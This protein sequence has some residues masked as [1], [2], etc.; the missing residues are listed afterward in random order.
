MTWRTTPTVAW[1]ACGML[2]LMP[3][4]PILVTGAAGFIG[5]HVVDALVARGYEV[6]A[7]DALLPA[8]HA[9]RPDYLNPGAEWLIGDLRD[10]DLARRAVAGV[11][12]VCH[13]ASMVGLG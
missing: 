4:G 10:P 8:A 3:D 6:R 12:A 9:G 5:S 11:S 13:Q 1:P 2:D 7:V